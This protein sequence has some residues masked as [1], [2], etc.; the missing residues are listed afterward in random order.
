VVDFCARPLAGNGKTG[1][2]AVRRKQSRYL[3]WYMNEGR[4][5]GRRFYPPVNAVWWILLAAPGPMRTL[6]SQL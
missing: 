4:V 2:L 6:H 3:L 1:L 5:H